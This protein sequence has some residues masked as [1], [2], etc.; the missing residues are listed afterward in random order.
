[1]NTSP[2]PDRALADSIARELSPVALDEGDEL[3]L[4]AVETADAG[5]EALPPRS[6]REAR[7]TSLALLYE[8][9]IRKVSPREVLDAQVV[10]PLPLTRGALAGI[11]EQCAAIDARIEAALD[12]WRLERLSPIDRSLLRLGVWELTERLDVPTGAVL[13]EMVELASRYSSDESGRFV[14]G[15]LSRVAADVRPDGG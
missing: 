14:N 15:V 1:M 3:V 6:R 11:A 8:A 7:E 9:E 5:A 13:S 10:T 2:E 12:R 4:E